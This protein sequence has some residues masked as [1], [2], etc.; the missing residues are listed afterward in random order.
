MFVV[1][2]FE[3]GVVTERD[4]RD[5]FD[6]LESLADARPLYCVPF[7]GQRRRADAYIVR[8]RWWFCC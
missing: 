6:S 1:D 8:Y 4:A 3:V 7:V 5:E 2:D